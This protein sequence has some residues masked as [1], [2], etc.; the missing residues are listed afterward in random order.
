[1]VLGDPPHRP[2]TEADWRPEHFEQECLNG[3]VYGA[4]KAKAERYAW[5]FMKTC[6]PHF[7]LTTF[8]PGRS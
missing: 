4:S 3:E 7:A 2:I 8:C 1:M 5:D 6:K